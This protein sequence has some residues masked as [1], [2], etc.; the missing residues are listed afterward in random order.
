MIG[1]LARLPTIKAKVSTLIVIAIGTAAVTSQL[2][3]RA[4]W[5]RW[6]RIALAA[7]VSLVLVQ[8]ASRGLT[9]PLRQMDAAVAR[10][11]QGDLTAR[12][13]VEGRDEVARLA[14]GFNAMAESLGELDR[15][16][17]DLLANASH[18]LRTPIAGIQATLENLV[19]GV[20]EPTPHRLSDLQRQV[21]RLGTLVNE[22]LDL[23]RL[24]A[25]A[26]SLAPRWV[27]AINLLD[28]AAESARWARAGFNVGCHVER[29]GLAVWADPNR[30]HQV[31]VNLLDNA[32]RFSST[33][34]IS[35]RPADDGGVIIDV[36]DAGPGIPEGEEGRVFERFY[37]ADQSRALSGTGAGL[38]LPIARWI[39]ELHGGRI[40]AVPARPSGCRITISLPAP[41]PAP[42]PAVLPT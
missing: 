32:A 24:E 33:A 23:S 18:E 26:T 13:P 34:E 8:L 22:L 6:F 10:M 14:V 38:G 36:I 16:R 29:E 5:P 27:S 25:G 42:P 35:A 9:R 37:R 11:A 40:C 12:V 39:V 21:E 2:G 28:E 3:Y 41:A 19:D 31:L 7:E 17:R 15:L 1:P 4:S 30:L 20:I